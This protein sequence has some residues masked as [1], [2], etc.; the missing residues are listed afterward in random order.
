ML[1]HIYSSGEHIRTPWSTKIQIFFF[2][3]FFAVVD[4][5]V[6]GGKLPRLPPSSTAAVLFILHCKLTTLMAFILISVVLLLMHVILA[7]A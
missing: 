4:C 7:P 3:K 1:T 6:G 5:Q 2:Q